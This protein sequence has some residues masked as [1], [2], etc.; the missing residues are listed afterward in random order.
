M[1]ISQQLFC[2]SML[3]LPN[4]Y[5]DHNK[6]VEQAMG[7]GLEPV[8]KT[9]FRKSDNEKKFMEVCPVWLIP[10]YIFFSS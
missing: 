1:E 6:F 3:Y 10:P 2:Y 7:E 5:S 4:L 8:D 9:H